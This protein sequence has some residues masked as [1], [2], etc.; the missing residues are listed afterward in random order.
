[1]PLF[2]MFVLQQRMHR[3][4]VWPCDQIKCSVDAWLVHNRFDKQP[5]KRT[6]LNCC[7]CCLC[8]FPPIR[9]H[10]SQTKHFRGFMS[11][12]ERIF[13]VPWRGVAVI[14]IL[15]FMPFYSA[16]LHSRLIF[17][18]HLKLA[19][20]TEKKHWH[21]STPHSFVGRVHS[22]HFIQI[23]AIWWQ[24]HRSAEHWTTLSLSLTHTQA[25]APTCRA[26]FYWK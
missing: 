7:R 10:K 11:S 26:L 4:F 16:A 19:W 9:V 5:A 15:L 1:M 20:N 14:H 13:H 6:P 8:H 23:L 25:R 2:I 21:P 18:T 24:I 3:W 12:S 22:A 17:Y